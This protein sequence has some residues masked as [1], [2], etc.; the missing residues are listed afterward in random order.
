MTKPESCITH[1]VSRF[2]QTMSDEIFFDE[3]AMAKLHK[4]GGEKFVRSMIDLFFDYA[5]KRIAA[6]RAGEQ[7]GDL[8]A[9]AKAVHPLKSSAGQIGAREIQE[10]CSQ[11][12]KLAT[13]NS[14][15]M[16]LSALQP[17]SPGFP[18][19]EEGSL[20]GGEGDIS[21]GPIPALLDQLETAL[22]RV[23]PRL[24]QERNSTS[25]SVTL[26]P[27]QPSSPGFPSGEGGSLKGGEG[28]SKS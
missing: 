9:I 6:A 5:P 15:E 4:L 8:V 10:L 25:Q 27:L 11:I 13:D 17:P 24:E 20:K 7:A 3:V 23:K 22:A 14:V 2:T 16:A 26:S 28:Q 18:S 19:S 1:H 21:R 12:E